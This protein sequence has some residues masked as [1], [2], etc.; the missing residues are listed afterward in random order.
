VALCALLQT[1]AFESVAPDLVLTYPRDHGAH[2]ATQTEWWY[3]TG[4][5]SD[6]RG[7]TFGFQ[8]TIF[9]RGLEPGPLPD[10]ASPLRARQVYAG[11]LALTDVTRGTTRFA[12]RARRASPLAGAAADRL[13]VRIDDW[14][15][16]QRP[17]ETLAL[18]AADL[19]L[20]FGFDFTLRPQKPLV[21]H[22]ERGYSKKGSAPGNASAYVSW[23]RLTLEGRLR[24]DE[25]ER[26]VRG[27]AW[28][29]HEFG[30][31]ALEPGIVGWDWFWAQ[32]DDGS[33]VML[34]T[35]R[36]A[37][38][39]IHPASAGTRVDRAGQAT[40]LRREDFVLRPS[41]TWK[42][43]RTGASYPAVWTLTIPSAKLE[44]DLAP[45][46]PDCEL[47]SRTTGVVYW[48]G[49]IAVRGSSTGRGYAELT[50]Y[51]GSLAGRF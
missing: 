25:G 22:G 27:T 33:E 26:T 43:P 51:S 18:I 30:T 31:S 16:V 14:S 3:I 1:P 37:Q 42:S 49:P 39:G 19:A 7:A 8:F 9:R 11:H 21:F 5:L 2:E 12:E 48:E 44:L 4:H 24:L 36:D 28:F 20:G 17:D 32:L 45:L 47:I 34:F 29:D 6:E 35:L 46:V 13:D 41:T 23:P 38:G 50:G 40:V 15:L 10:L